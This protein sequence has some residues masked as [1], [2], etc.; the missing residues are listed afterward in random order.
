MRTERR[1][2][3][4]KLPRGSQA[5]KHAWPLESCVTTLQC[6]RERQVCTWSWCYSARRR[7]VCVQPCQAAE[8]VTLFRSVSVVPALRGCEDP[9]GGFHAGVCAATM[10]EP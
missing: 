8:Q 5:A 9:R 7:S 1:A 6:G 4:T 3:V 2:A 10:Q